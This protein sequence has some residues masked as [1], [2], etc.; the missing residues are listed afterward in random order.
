MELGSFI[1]LFY[2][3]TQIGPTG[4]GFKPPYLEFVSIWAGQKLRVVMPV[5]ERIQRDVLKV[6]VRLDGGILITLMCFI[7]SSQF[8]TK[9]R[10][11]CNLE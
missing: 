9:Q 4:V 3:E 1:L 6:S 11:L 10:D 5:T 2:K 8:A 7:R